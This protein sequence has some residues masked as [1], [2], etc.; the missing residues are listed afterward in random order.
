MCYRCTSHTHIQIALDSLLMSWTL[1]ITKDPVT[2]LIP[3][4]VIFRAS[5][6]SRR[7]MK[8]RQVISK[9]PKGPGPHL[10]APA[11]LPNAFILLTT[12]WQPHYM[13][14]IIRRG[15]PE[16]TWKNGVCFRYAR[17]VGYR[18]LANPR[19]AHLRCVTLS[20]QSTSQAKSGEGCDVGFRCS[21]LDRTGD[22]PR[23]YETN[24]FIH[25]FFAGDDLDTHGYEGPSTWGVFCCIYLS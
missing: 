14:T 12:P 10:F 2:L 1:F 25:M 11:M 17:C 21:G 3:K 18:L 15:N 24:I 22:W 5:C 6:L 23:P 8:Y 9:G 7:F 13:K 4:V 19:F 16:K 20:P